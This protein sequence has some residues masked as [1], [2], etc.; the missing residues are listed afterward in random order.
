MS[1]KRQ[2]NSE[3]RQGQRV[4]N[5]N[6]IHKKPEKFKHYKR[7]LAKKEKIRKITRPAETILSDLRRWQPTRA[8]ITH[9][10]NGTPTNITHRPK[11]LKIGS[12]PPRLDDIAYFTNP[13]RAMVCVRRKVRRQVLHALKK[14]GK[15]AKARRKFN[16]N[17]KI[18]C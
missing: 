6:S 14:T 15:G 3:V 17:S 11:P 4:T 7:M 12:E 5:A 9:Y 1:R 10:R 2:K 8:K 16:E 13:K 18:R